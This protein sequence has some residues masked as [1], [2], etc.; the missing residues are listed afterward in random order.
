M[1]RTLKIIEML[2]NTLYNQIMLTKEMQ[3][4]VET[5]GGENYEY[6]P[7]G[8]YVVRAVGVCNSAPTFKYTRI[9]VSFVLGLLASGETVDEIVAGYARPQLTHSAIY[10]AIA[11]ANSIFSNSEYATKPLAV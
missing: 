7:L 3:L 11:L 9:N 1:S 5:V 10:E 2:R 8:E 4:V 6:Y